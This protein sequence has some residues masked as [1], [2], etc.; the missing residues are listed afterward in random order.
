MYQFLYTLQDSGKIKEVSSDQ[1]YY[2]HGDSN[3]QHTITQYY[4]VRDKLERNMLIPDS[5]GGNAALAFSPI[6]FGVVL[7]L[8]LLFIPQL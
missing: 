7:P 6:Q 8:S 4:I 1:K 3:A 5:C 2:V